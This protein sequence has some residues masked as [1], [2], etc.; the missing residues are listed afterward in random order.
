MRC[1]LHTFEAQTINRLLTCGLPVGQML[2]QNR[3][4]TL[5]SIECL[6]ELMCERFQI[7]KR[8]LFNLTYFDEGRSLEEKDT[9]TCCEA[10]SSN[11]IQSQRSRSDHHFRARQHSKSLGVTFC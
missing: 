2:Y 5:A 8:S 1:F 10:C 7:I 9:L 6:S 3:D 11:V 4:L